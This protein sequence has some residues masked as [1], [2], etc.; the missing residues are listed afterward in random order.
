MMHH[1]TRRRFLLN[2]SLLW[3]GYSLSSMN[4]A[5]AGANGATG[6]GQLARDSGNLF[7][8]PQENSAYLKTLGID[9]AQFLR[10]WKAVIVGKEEIEPSRQEAFVASF[11]R[12]LSD[13]SD[14]LRQEVAMLSRMLDRFWGRWLVFGFTDPL[15]STAINVLS[16]RIE[17]LGASA[18]SFRRKTR[19]GLVTL[20]GISH[21][22]HPLLVA[23]SG[24]RGAPS[25]IRDLW[26]E[27]P[28]A[29][30][31]RSE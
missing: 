3:G 28:T 17:V 24:Y 20:M 12:L 25:H 4:L 15:E 9:P 14:E 6:Q 22:A 5:F 10:I 30:G 7:L 2:L 29:G 27:S 21:Y 16:D 1:S 18:L 8:S 11:A 26:V 31:A 23:D 13:S 19:M